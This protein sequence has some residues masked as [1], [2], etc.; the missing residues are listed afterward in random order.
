MR[1]TLVAAVSLLAF[2]ATGYSQDA[3]P[4]ATQ[5]TAMEE[6]IGQ[7]AT[8]IVWSSEAGRIAAEGSEAVLTA[9]IAENGTRQMRGIEIAFTAP[10]AG[11]DKVYV[12][13]EFF[14]RLLGALDDA[15]MSAPTV[16]GCMGS[17]KFL[18]AMR[19]GAHFFFA[20]QCTQTGVNVLQAGTGRGF[21]FFPNVDSAPFAGAIRN[22]HAQLKE[23]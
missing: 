5:L 20:S 9:I 22:A 3:E 13:Q 6:F 4:T 8:R 21:F 23:R 1:R 19:A 11:Q 16:R 12:S 10:Q 15:S 7:P 17:G 18:S 2:S 14:E